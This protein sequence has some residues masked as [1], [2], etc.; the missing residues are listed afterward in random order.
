MSP[1]NENSLPSLRLGVDTGGTFT[2]FAWLDESGRLRIHKQLSTPHDP[3]EAILAGLAAVQI[4]ETAAIVHGST[5]AT[6]A[7]LERR[8]ARTA[9]I[10]TAGFADVLAI[11][12]QNR[13]EL[14]A[15]VPQKPEPLVPRH[16]RFEVRER[17]T[18][19]GEILVP[20]DLADVRSIL[21][22]LVADQI[23][24]V[25]VCLLFSFLRPEHEQLIKDVLAAGGNFHLSLSSEILPEYREYERTAATVIN[26]YVAPLMA[27][28]LGRLAE[29]LAP[30]PLAVMQSNGGVIGARTAGQQAAR[31]VLSG[32]AGGV[33]GARFVAGPAGYDQIIS[34]DM[35]GTSTDV[36]L[37]PGRLPVTAEG[38]IAGLPLRLPMIDIHTVGA[39]GGSLAGVDAGGAL[40]V[41][42]QS[43][44]ATPGPA[45][46]GLAGRASLPQ[47]TVTDANLVLG[48]LDAGHFLGGAMRLDETAARLALAELARAMAVGSAEEAAWGVL[49]VA[50]ATMERAIRRI[51]VER[52]YDPRDFTLVAFGGAGPLHACD[53]AGS[54]QIPQVLI[55]GAPGVL[56]A[57]GMLAAAPAKDYSQTVM[58]PVGEET[59]GGGWLEVV[60][61]G[62]AE[63]A[64]AEMAAEGYGGSEVVLQ[65]SLD[66]RYAGQSHELTIPLG[67][68][69]ASG[70]VSALFH[71]AHERRYG[72]S[73][74]EATVE[75]VNARLAAVAS[76][77]RPAL[78]QQPA[79]EADATP[80]VVG[81]K[82]V[83]FDRRPAPTT[84]YDREKLRPGHRFAG[85]A[86][87]F[88][89]DTTTV[90]PPGWDAVVDAWGLTLVRS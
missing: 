77:A 20:L 13:P 79:G 78:P 26:A 12:R 15:L 89:Y 30:R 6:N 45:C 24:S 27:R 3:A 7:L 75:V 64:L 29:G 1:G 80:A 33:V 39:G 37:C 81:Q 40:H 48:R 67:D 35:G 58:R 32:P 65:R 2:D 57:L 52:G 62:L 51:S 72:Y 87:V 54:L 88:Q 71:R 18:A 90:I 49:Q 21:A 74:P 23:E 60:F 25:A 63:R 34:F 83:W 53:L 8:G 36:A 43:A 56:S 4:P 9:L 84:L 69:T 73:R 68:E 22:R 5:V 31:T 44:G 59:R 85:P 41:G 66:V 47:A 10:T 86:V 11:G 76:I 16:W 61:R 28:Y 46:Y 50:N 42:P 70:P 82:M 17:I 19:E 14:Y 38:E 55:P